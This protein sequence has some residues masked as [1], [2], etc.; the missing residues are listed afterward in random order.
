[1]GP[2]SAYLDQLGQP[3]L[4]TSVVAFI[5]VLGFSN[6][7]TS[8]TDLE[9]AQ[10]TLAMIAAAI[11]DSRSFVRES[12]PRD[13]SGTEIKAALKFFSDNLAFACPCDGGDS[14]NRA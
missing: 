5:D 8:G 13:S 14:D 3:R 6:F 10:R 1:M 7:S 2:A 9:E 11:N 4:R 12:V